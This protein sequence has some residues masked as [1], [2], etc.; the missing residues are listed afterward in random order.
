LYVLLEDEVVVIAIMHLKR[1]PGYW[2]KRL[3]SV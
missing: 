1:K 3:K 2:K